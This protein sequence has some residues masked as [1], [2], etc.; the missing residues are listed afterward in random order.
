MWSPFKS[1]KIHDVSRFASGLYISG[2]GTRELPFVG[3]ERHAQHSPIAGL[4]EIVAP[5]RSIGALPAPD[6]S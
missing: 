5:G 6:V 3:K 4:F 2:R 1:T